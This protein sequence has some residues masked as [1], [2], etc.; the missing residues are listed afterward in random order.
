MLPITLSIKIYPFK[1]N[2]NQD[3]QRKIINSTKIIQE[4]IYMPSYSLY[5]QKLAFQDSRHSEFIFNKNYQKAIPIITSQKHSKS[6]SISP[7]I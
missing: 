1:N 2:Q 6:L 5:S 7:A 4:L 3:F